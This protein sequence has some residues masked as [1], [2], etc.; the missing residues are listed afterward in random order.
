MVSII[1][2][3]FEKLGESLQ[4][5]ISHIA[6]SDK[7]TKGAYYSEGKEQGK[8]AVL[9]SGQGSQY[10]G[11]IRELA[12]N[13]PVITDVLS[14]ADKC[15]NEA[16]EKRF[17]KNLSD[18]IYP[19]GT[20]DDAAKK[21]AEK[22]LTGT[23]IAQPALGAVESGLWQLAKGFG[24]N[25]DMLAGHSYGEFV[26]LYASGQIS[27]ADLM[28]ISE[29][30][31]R[32]IVDKAKEAGLELG[33]MAAVRA[34][35]K[36][37]EAIIK[38]IDGV[39]VAN[40]NSHKQIIISGSKDGIKVACEKLSASGCKRVPLPVSAAFHSSFV[41]PA[42]LSLEKVINEINWKENTDIAVYSNNTAKPHTNAKKAMAGHLTGSVE[43]VAQ[44]DIC[45]MTGL[46]FSLSL[47]LKTY[48]QSWWGRYWVIR[49]THL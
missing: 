44:I 8:L 16:F 5:A 10:T 45:I 9:F 38:D 36:D 47:G 21:A 29:A 15:L 34:D 25:A 37:V 31:G 14:D 12:Y 2:D 42:R 13:F 33:T 23:D 6:N 7:L 46:G 39:V 3:S 35:R 19:H 43:F 27:F 1:A 28:K 49:T 48:L 4:N 32:L 17:D 11:M 20:Y 18:F 26:A 40:H 30:R 22:A 24:I 41:E